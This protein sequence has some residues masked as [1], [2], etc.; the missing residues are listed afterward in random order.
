MITI[1][2]I[3]K[4]KNSVWVNKSLRIHYVRTEFFKGEVGFEE[5]TFRLGQFSLNILP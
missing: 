3:F 1:I 2:V 5:E 4:Q